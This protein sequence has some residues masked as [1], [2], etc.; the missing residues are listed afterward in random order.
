MS[1][2]NSAKK[3]L[4]GTTFISSSLEPPQTPRAFSHKSRPALHSHPVPGPLCPPPQRGLPLL[5]T[6]RSPE[7][8]ELRPPGRAGAGRERAARVPG[9]AEAA[10]CLGALGG[11]GAAAIRTCQ[12][13]SQDRRRRN[14]KSPCPSGVPAP[15]PGGGARIPGRGLGGPGSPS[16]FPC[17]LPGAWPGPDS[18]SARPCAPPH[19]ALTHTHTPSRALTHA[20]PSLLLCLSP[21]AV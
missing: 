3:S 15:L 11:Q 19:T 6:P 7:A 5:R 21:P 18:A 12:A 13:F 1:N 10:P 4:D 16:P 2:K 9:A 14:F 20:L 8:G 17:S